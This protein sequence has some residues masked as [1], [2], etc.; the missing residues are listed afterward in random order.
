MGCID[1]LPG[2]AFDVSHPCIHLQ[3]GE[4]HDAMVPMPHGPAKRGPVWKHS[5]VNRGGKGSRSVHD[6][7]GALDGVDHLS[8]C[9]WFSERSVETLAGEPGDLTVRETAAHADQPRSFEVALVLKKIAGPA[10]IVTA[11]LQI[12]EH[13]M[14]AESLAFDACREWIAC[15]ANDIVGLFTENAFK[16]AEYFRVA[17]DNEYAGVTRHQPVEGNAVLPHESGKGLHWNPPVLGAWDAVSLELAGVEPLADRACG[18]IADLGNFAGC[19]YVLVE[20]IHHASF[21]LCWTAAF[22]RD[23]GTAQASARLKA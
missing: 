13:D 20:R 18:D 10:E 6:G 23:G 22:P 14:R 16:C 4:V 21:T 1:D 12:H 9:E 17:I 3:E 19:K 15:G 8:Y 5:G 7:G 2:I 11:E